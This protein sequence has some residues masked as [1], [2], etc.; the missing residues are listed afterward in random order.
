[1]TLPVYIFHWL[2]YHLLLLFVWSQNMI[3]QISVFSSLFSLRQTLP[4]NDYPPAPRSPPCLQPSPFTL[5]PR[6]HPIPCLCFR[7]S[8][9]SRAFASPRLNSNTSYHIECKHGALALDLVHMVPPAPS[10]F[11]FNSRLWCVLVLGASAG[12]CLLAFS[13]S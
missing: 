2:C 4:S 1:M 13:P 7:I 8:W 11:T 3:E 6:P 5:L 9:G 10:S 12:S